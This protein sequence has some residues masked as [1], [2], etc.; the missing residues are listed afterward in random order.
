MKQIKAK[1]FVNKIKQ[2][3]PKTYSLLARKQFFPTL[4]LAMAYSLKL[5]NNPNVDE[6]E[7]ALYEKD[8]E[9]TVL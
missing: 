4:L 5:I 7:T 3:I 6:E 1:L 9:E 2:S 8:E